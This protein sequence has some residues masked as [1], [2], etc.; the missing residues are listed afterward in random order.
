M[1]IEDLLRTSKEKKEKRL[2][3]VIAVDGSSH[4][5]DCDSLLSVKDLSYYLA[6]SESF[7]Y[8]MIKSGFEMPKHAVLRYRVS[9]YIKAVKWLED[10]PDFKFANA[11]K[12]KSG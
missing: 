7:I 3:A 12:H 4:M 1:K 2:L 5:L 6:K 10:N 8:A 11:Y 9:T